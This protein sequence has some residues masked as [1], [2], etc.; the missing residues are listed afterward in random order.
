MVSY[1]INTSKYEVKKS[2]ILEPSDNK[3]SKIKSAPS[4][5]LRKSDTTTF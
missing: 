4:E 5:D 1:Y 2:I 3:I